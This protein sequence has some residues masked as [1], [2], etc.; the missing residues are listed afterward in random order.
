MEFNLKRLL[1]FVV[2]LVMVLS[3]VP[4]DGLQV[5]AADG[6]GESQTETTDDT[7][8]PEI[9]KATLPEAATEAIQHG[10]D[11]QLAAKTAVADNYCPACDKP[12]TW[13]LL[14]VGTTVN[15]PATAEHHYYV[16]GTMKSTAGNVIQ[17]NDMPDGAT[18]CL[19]LEE[20]SVLDMTGRLLFYGY[21]KSRTVNIMGTGTIK[22]TNGTA[23]TTSL[24]SVTA[25]KASTLNLYGGRFYSTAAS[26][27]NRAV[28]RLEGAEHILNIWTDDVKIGPETKGTSVQYNVDVRK[29]TF[30]M[31]AGTI[32]NGYCETTYQSPNVYLYN[33]TTFNMY[34]GTIKDGRAIH[35]GNVYMC[36]NSTATIYG[37]IEGGSAVASASA[38]GHG[39]NIGGY[40]ATVSVYGT[41]KDGTAT[42]SAE[43]TANGGNIGLGTSGDVKSTLVLGTGADISGGTT[44]GNGGNIYMSSG[45][46]TMNNGHIYNGTAVNG[47]NLYTTS[48]FTMHNGYIYDGAATAKGGNVCNGGTFT[49][50]D[51]IIKNGINSTE[52]GIAYGGNV[53]NSVTFTM[54]NGTITGGQSISGDDIAYGGNVY[55]SGT[56][57]MNNG[58]IKEGTVDTNS[59]TTATYGGN[60]YS[61]K[62]FTINGGVIKDGIAKQT[63]SESAKNYFGGNIYA[64]STLT[65][66]N[67][68][69]ANGDAKRG[70]NIYSAGKLTMENSTLTKGTTTYL[71]GS[72]YLAAGADI[73]NSS[74]S[75]GKSTVSNGGNI[76]LMGGTL[77]LTNC[78][79][80]GGKAPGYGG[81]IAVYTGT[82]LNADA[83]TTISDGTSSLTGGN[84][85]VLGTANIFGSVS[86]GKAP[87]G[88]SIYV[89][90]GTAT[91]KG[92][93]T[94]GSS[95]D[96]GNIKVVNNGNLILDGATVSGGIMTGEAA[97]ATNIRVNLGTLTLKGNTQVNELIEGTHPG[98]ILLAYGTQGDPATNAKLVVDPTFEGNVVFYQTGDNYECLS[99]LHDATCTGAF[100]GTLKVNSAGQDHANLVVKYVETEIDGETVGQ[101]MIPHVEVALE[102]KDPTC[103]ETGLGE[104]TECDVC[105]EV[106]TAQPV[107][108]ANGH[109]MTFTAAVAPSCTEDGNVAY[110]TCGVCGKNFS[111]EAG[112]NELAYVHYSDPGR[113][114]ALV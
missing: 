47:G 94:G 111:D 44:G 57:T 114:R 20:G 76:F 113:R 69:I 79:I 51:G 34:G 14:P 35:G 95:G 21:Q 8:I 103:T 54:N 90:K 19:L 18:L 78:D 53:Y 17:T 107:L 42:V 30:N 61:S 86:G 73:T 68:E 24:L 109:S 84:V 87:N 93:V 67:A 105:G 59:T 33:Y 25:S 40:G 23:T 88:G 99:V 110:Y 81:N 49:M 71:G 32:Q 85:H 74:I 82:T 11:V 1:S 27:K 101:L 97:L 100:T 45:T 37:T 28:V 83:D 43:K 64:E 6:D 16:T 80:T 26:N 65:V 108:P 75:E 77:N 3:M 15:K 106:I 4:F 96:G 89:D 58:T 46:F 7:P 39:G 70:G 66:K 63:G 112:E 2:A 9:V 38:V 60:I 52:T 62:A 55:N 102:A 31:Y 22:T 104:G 91:I 29:G 41:V 56:F 10:K 50:N 13:T 92:S 72:I 36:P 12:V 5:F 48:A 98:G